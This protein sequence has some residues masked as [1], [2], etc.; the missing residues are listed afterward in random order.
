MLTRIIIAVCIAAAAAVTAHAADVR[1]HSQSLRLEGNNSVALMLVENVGASH[2]D[3]VIV[4]CDFYAEGVPVDRGRG[5]VNAI[6]PKSDAI[7]KVEIVGL[8]AEARCRV[9][10]VR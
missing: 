4:T 9:T 10:S 8:S 3:S 7:A 1:I 2:I 5:L 6:P